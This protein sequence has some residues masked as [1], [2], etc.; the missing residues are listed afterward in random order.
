[1]LMLSPFFP[2]SG[3]KPTAAAPP[4]VFVAPVRQGMTTDATSSQAGVQQGDKTSLG[5]SDI[6]FVSESQPQSNDNFC[7]GCLAFVCLCLIIV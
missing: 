1:M 6:T 5:V 2:P 4:F 7:L 3:D